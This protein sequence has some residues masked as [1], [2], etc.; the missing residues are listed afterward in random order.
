MKNHFEIKFEIT[1]FELEEIENWLKEELLTS[2]NGFY[3]NWNLITK[4]IPKIKL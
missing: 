1:N 4:H 3:H 2:N